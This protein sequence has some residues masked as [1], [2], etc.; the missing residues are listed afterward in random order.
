MKENM[1]IVRIGLFTRLSTRLSHT[2]KMLLTKY[3]S[4]LLG[5]GIAIDEALEIIGE[6]SKGTMKHIMQD[7]K[8][9]VNSGNTLSRGFARYP[10]IFPPIFINLV[11]AGE[12]SGTLQKNLEYLSVQLEK[13]HALRQKIHGALLYPIIVLIGAIL[14]GTGIILFV[15]P[16]IVSLFANLNT[17]IPR[18]TRALL[19]LSSTFQHHGILI[20]L[21]FP[22][23]IFVLLILKRLTWIQP[24]THWLLL[25]LPIIG[26]MSKSIN[27]AR[28][29]RTLGILLSSGQPINDALIV[30]SS[31][32][33]NVHYQKLFSTVRNE[34]LQGH[35]LTEVLT[36]KP[37]LIPPLTLRLITVGERTGTLEKML[38]YIADFYEQEVNDATKNLSSL[39]EPLFIFLI[40]LI[41]ASLALAII[42]PIYKIV[43]SV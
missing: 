30:T 28:T 25:H 6:Q 32:T 29:T 10:H 27:L 20:L 35:T 16:N 22:T 23:T 14:V 33:R 34:V 5:S 42:S 19:W 12:A 36:K 11:S 21:L 17:E 38:I 24:I 1:S 39:M 7:L 15:L 37:A 26:K 3:L 31:M 8:S 9:I 4:V 43:G 40:G 41:V 13:E 2:E 18:S